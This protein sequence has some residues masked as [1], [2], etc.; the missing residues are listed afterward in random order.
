MPSH[1]ENISRQ[2]AIM[3][4]AASSPSPAVRTLAK[5]FAE[6]LA[7]IKRIHAKNEVIAARTLR[8]MKKR[9]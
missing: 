3:V 7:H 6:N 4:Q 5:K 1:T 2:F 8:S 9:G